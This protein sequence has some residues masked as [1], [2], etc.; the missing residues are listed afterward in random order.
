MER[1]LRWSFGDGDRGGTT[2]DQTSVL[3]WTASPGSSS[4]VAGLSNFEDGQT[5]GHSASRIDFSN[6]V[7]TSQ[8]GI[9]GQPSATGPMALADI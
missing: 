1:R 8:S 2:R 9:I 5:E 6:V 3:A 4:L 7:I